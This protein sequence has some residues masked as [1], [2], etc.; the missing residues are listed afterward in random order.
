M[1]KSR[2]GVLLTMS[3]TNTH[4]RNVNAPVLPLWTSSIVAVSSPTAGWLETMYK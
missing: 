4:H 3:V 2:V 1:P